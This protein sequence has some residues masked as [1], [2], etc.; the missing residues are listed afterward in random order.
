MK[1]YRP[2]PLSTRPTVSVVIPCYN[3]GRYLRDVVGSVQKQPGIDV[4][5]LIIDDASTDNSAHEA[6]RLAARHPNVELIVHERNHGHIATYNEGLN[7]ADGRYLVLL[8]ADDLLTPGSLTRSVALLEAHPSVGFVYGY[9]LEFKD[10]ASLPPARDLVR[11]WSIWPGR[12]WLEECCRQGKNMVSTP[13]VV[14][15]TSLY[16]ELGGYEADFPHAGDFLMW[17]RAAAR[18]D[19]GRVNGPA[20]AY[21]RVHGQNMHLTSYAGVVTDL[22]ERRRTFRRLF[23]EDG[24]SL[25]DVARLQKLADLG[26]A[27]EAMRLAIA[28]VDSA[29]PQIGLGMQ[30]AAVAKELDPRIDRT[31]AWQHYDTSRSRLSAGRRRGPVPNAVRLFQTLEGKLRWRRWRWSGL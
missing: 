9:S 23:E 28:V 3:Y 10:S 14:M 2:V 7:L 20:Q 16:R 29:D 15:R 26:M 31:L 13:E 19:V 12:S 4:N 18:A 21:Y 24:E 22:E 25:H 8:S 1:P 11:N 30:F 6:R 5:I 17:L 27:R